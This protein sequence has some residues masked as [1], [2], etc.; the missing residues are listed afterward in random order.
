MRDQNHPRPAVEQEVDG[1]LSRPQ[2]GV[3]GDPSFRARAGQGDVEVDARKHSAVA[4]IGVAHAGLV[5]AASLAQTAAGSRS[6]TRA[7]SSTQRFEYPHSLSYQAITLTKLPPM[8]IVWP[9]SKIAECGSWT[10]S[11]ETIGSS[12]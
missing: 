3:I 4:H 5:E 11:V 8:T 2:A 1:R 12:V 6:S 9:A 7:A 10:M